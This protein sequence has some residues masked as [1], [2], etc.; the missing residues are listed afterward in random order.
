[1]FSTRILIFETSAFVVQ[2]EQATWH[3]R[4]GVRCAM[5]SSFGAGGSYAHA[6]VEEYKPEQSLDSLYSFAEPI[7]NKKVIIPLSARTA[8]RLPILARQLITF[9][10]DNTTA[11]NI[12]DVAYTL[13]TGR[14]PLEERLVVLAASL[15]E[16]MEKLDGYVQFEENGQPGVYRGNSK[17]DRKIL[18]F[19]STDNDIN[20]VFQKWIASGD[21]E[22]IAN[23]W[24]KGLRLDW[25]RLYPNTGPKPRRVSLPKY[26]FAGERYWLQAIKSNGRQQNIEKGRTEGRA[27]AELNRVSNAFEKNVPN[28]NFAYQDKKDEEGVFLPETGFF[29]T[30]PSDSQSPSVFP[31][32]TEKPRGLALAA[33]NDFGSTAQVTSERKKDCQIGPGEIQEAESEVTSPFINAFG[34]NARQLIPSAENLCHELC[35]SLAEALY[36]KP[37]DVDLDQPFVNMGLDSIIGVEWIQSLNAQYS[38]SMTATQVY[39][40]PTI[41]SLTDYLRDE[42]ARSDRPAPLTLEKEPLPIEDRSD[43]TSISTPVQKST[44]V[45]SAFQAASVAEKRPVKSA[46]ALRRELTISLAEALYMK[47]EDVDLDQPFVNMGLDSIIGVEWIQS[48]N[49]QYSLSMTATQVYDYPTIRS[50]TDYLRDEIARSDRPAP[51]TLEKEPLP[52]EDRSDPTSISTPVQKSTIVPSAFQAASVAEKRPVKSAE[53][54]RRELTISLAEALYMKP[55]DVDLDQ[56]FVN[57]GLDSIIGV[58]WIQS[59]NAQY[60]LSMTATQVYDYPNIREMA[61][62][63]EK[64]CASY[65]AVP[66]PGDP[67]P[68]EPLSSN[69]ANPIAARQDLSHGN[70]SAKASFTFYPQNSSLDNRLHFNSID[71][72]GDFKA[73]G[74]IS[75]FYTLNL[76][77]NV[78]TKHH[79]VFGRPTFPTDAYIELVYAACRTYFDLN[80]AVLKNISF[81]NPLIGH[82]EELVSIVIVFQRCSEGLRFKVKSVPSDQTNSQ[83]VHMRGLIQP[84]GDTVASSNR[85]TKLLAGDIETQFNVAS[86]YGRQSN[87]YLGDFYRSLK[88]LTFSSKQAVGEI[89]PSVSQAGF[90]L[91]PSILNAA[92]ACIISYGAYQIG[93]Q[94]DLAGDCFLPYKINKLSILGPIEPTACF[95]YA[96]V[97]KIEKDGV[98]LRF[99]I[100]D[101][102]HRALLVCDSIGLRRVSADKFSAVGRGQRNSAASDFTITFN[103]KPEPVKSSSI[104]VAIIGMACRFPQCKDSDAFWEV[105]KSGV[106]CITEVPS[107]RWR[108]YKHWYHPDPAHPHTS[109]SKWG[110]FIDDIDKFD[111]YFFNIAPAEAETMDPQ[112]RIFLEE[113]WKAIESA[114][115]NHRDLSGQSCGVYVGCT[116]GDYL[117]VLAHCGQDTLGSTF[118]GTSS[119]ILA[120]RIS[121]FLN[122]KGPSLSLDTACSSSLYTVHLASESI[123]QGENELAV[124]GGI[125]L[126]VTPWINILTSQVGMQSIDGRCRTFDETANGTV[127]S[128]GCGVVF[129]KALDKAL[130]DG[131]PILGII[132]GSGVNQDGKTN[133]ITAPSA[134][135]QEKLI[136]G[137]YRKFNIDPAHITYVEAHGTATRLGDPIEVQAITGA[138]E[139]SKVDRQYCAIGSVKTNIGHSAYSAGIAGLIKVLLVLKHKKYVPSLHYQKANP[140]IDFAQTPFYVN[141]DYKDWPV[142]ENQK[143]LAAISSF[144]FS[145]TN[146]HMVIQQS[147]LPESRIASYLLPRQPDTPMI[148]PLSAKTED[149]LR[150]IAQ[151]LLTFLKKQCNDEFVSGDGDRQHM[152]FPDLADIA[153]TLQIGREQMDARVAFIVHNIKDLLEK[154]E[155][156]LQTKHSQPECYQG[157]VRENKVIRELFDNDQDLEDTVERWIHNRK[158]DK[159]LNLWVKGLSIDWSKLYGTVRPNRINLPTYPFAR[160]RCWVPDLNEPLGLAGSATDRIVPPAKEIKLSAFEVTWR[161]QV[162]SIEIIA[163]N[164]IW[165]CL[166]SEENHQQTFERT[167]HAIDP[168]LNLIFIVSGDEYERK[169]AQHYQ[170]CVDD[171]TT[172]TQALRSILAEHGTVDT[173]HYLWPLEDPEKIVNVTP[174]SALCKTLAELELEPDRII[175]AGAADGTFPQCYLDAWTGFS[176]LLAHTLPNTS[177]CLILEKNSIKIDTSQIEYWAS[178]L[179]QESVSAVDTPVL[180]DGTKRYLAQALH[181]QRF[182]RLCPFKFQGVYL[183][184]NGCSLLGYCLA[185]YLVKSVAAKLILTGPSDLSVKQQTRLDALEKAGGSVFYLAAD[186][187]DPTQMRKGVHEAQQTIGAIC[188]TIHTFDGTPIEPF[189]GDQGRAVIAHLRKNAFDMDGL[190]SLCADLSLDFRCFIFSGSSSTPYWNEWEGGEHGD[191]AR[192]VDEQFR[193]AW[194]EAHN[195]SQASGHAIAIDWQVPIDEELDYDNSPELETALALFEQ[196]LSE[197]RTQ[198]FIQARSGLTCDVPRAVTA[199]VNTGLIGGLSGMTSSTH[200]VENLEDRV[201]EDLRILVHKLFKIDLKRLDV[202][203]DLAIFGFTSI[204]LIVFARKLSE[205]YGIEITPAVLFGHNTLKQL[206]AHLVASHEESMRRHYVESAGDVYQPNETMTPLQSMAS[207]T[208]GACAQNDLLTTSN[209]RVHMSTGPSEP[210]A[211]IGMSCKF[212]KAENPEMFWE[213]LKNGRDCI[214]EVP[215]NRWN[216]R[217]YYDTS[218]TGESETP[219]RWGGFLDDIGNFDPHFFGISPVEAEWMDPQ[220]RL[221]MTYAYAAIEDA[222][223]NPKGLSGRP[224]GVFIGTQNSGYTDL[225]EK[226]GVD[227]EAHTATGMVPSIGPNRL[228]YFLDLHGPSEPIETACASSLVAI[229]RG[230]MAINNG[231]CDMAIVGGINTIVTP[232]GYL[233]FSKAGLLSPNGRCKPFAHDA[234]GFVRSEGVGLLVIKKLSRAE[235]DGD[236]IYGL[237]R[238][239]TENHGGRS[240]MLT[241]PNPLAQ[242]EI[243]ASAYRDAGIDPRTVT[244]IEAHGT[245]TQLGDCIE[246]EALKNAFKLLY[247][248]TEPPFSAVTGRCQPEPP[249]CGLGSVKSNIG[250]TELA[251]GIAGIIKVL[252]QLK[253]KSLAKSLYCEKH[254]PYIELDDSPFYIINPAIKHVRIKQH[255]QSLDA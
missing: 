26:P 226:N 45:P 89:Q 170:V 144:G 246:I 217:E 239:C 66:V 157:H 103:R 195:I 187:N 180:Y 233:A 76:L 220:Q 209:D 191:L 111:P 48:L 13:Q 27:P 165:L 145:G 44:I 92:L 109:C 252:L 236:H 95:C 104:D 214:G 188:G 203:V 22:K 204:N 68:I 230:M 121:Y 193:L 40:Y 210:L 228:S 14:E 231:N 35:R 235:E 110:G 168:S 79:L 175:L 243:I 53:A 211:I 140:H 93:K 80:S 41:R 166:L 36:M 245:G 152:E 71:Y 33:R 19:L 141:T 169:T 57:M 61:H 155:A 3:G 122:L 186:F 162:L 207:Q 100:V 156:Y 238:S 2:K 86:L 15:D 248:E 177:V 54:L 52:I 158:T 149:R 255:K 219:V 161:E 244:Y 113:T 250:H 139:T 131:D 171:Q 67:Q 176:S 24:T 8:D 78:C 74:N 94:Y 247:R 202:N 49:A 28:S 62:F 198:T 84:N 146:V 179:H 60:G 38:L 107:E 32:S 242:T 117:R 97:N 83:I 59:L 118:T 254:N 148:I 85:F 31:D 114:G 142:V 1:M 23:L 199:A 34:G 182:E 205:F 197:K 7:T 249:H 183:I 112:Q 138:F 91:S 51:L 194:V 55:E 200:L 218:R 136:A 190:D 37:E 215:I 172:W 11:A 151:A 73:D 181:V 227:I 64:Q 147:P 229:R 108:L 150:V 128:E 192:R 232:L 69:A 105:L 184:T 212:P 164:R 208:M 29:A 167:I 129:L 154:L 221:L 90:L 237:I 160:E 10:K 46:E 4:D 132:K 119:A 20:Q 234:D 82:T 124:A 251:S 213:N 42:I 21:G 47:P 241:A 9:L 174:I 106:D 189:A 56:P 65:A 16:L 196:V 224:V 30:L 123:R 185:K 163:K 143:R 75:I 173:I 70:P 115:Y 12:V 125:N 102:N 81:I 120:S 17:T 223:Y 134:L 88:T 178:R 225:L 6:I 43:P 87:I 99:E 77:G 137:V 240:N 39:D 222:G 159:L 216:W 126:F 101:R 25:E 206:A 253:H 135:S 98:E 18:Q 153:Y 96:A 127:F 5:L 130:K 58:E 72:I 201:S 63:L 50:L 133:G 116:T